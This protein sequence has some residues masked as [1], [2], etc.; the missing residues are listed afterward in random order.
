M[1]LF[2]FHLTSSWLVALIRARHSQ[3]KRTSML[4]PSL[5]K[6][7]LFA[8]SG[9]KNTLF[10]TKS[11]ILRFNKTPPFLS[12]SFVILDKLSLF[13]KARIIVSNWK[14]YSIHIVFFIKLRY[15]IA[16]SKKKLGCELAMFLLQGI[17][18]LNG[19]VFVVE[20][21]QVT[22]EALRGAYVKMVDRHVSWVYCGVK[23][24]R[25][26]CCENILSFWI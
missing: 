9:R 19:D 15:K 11:V 7:T 1:G 2:I 6:L 16:S 3:P 23:W 21:E 10:S 26:Q 22:E 5:K 13:V 12:V 20:D 8:D 18:S 25:K 4:D 17:G 24:L 14:H